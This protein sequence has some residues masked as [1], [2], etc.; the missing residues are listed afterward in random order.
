MD[1]SPQ[2]EKPDAEFANV[3]PDHERPAWLQAF[4]WLLWIAEVGAFLYLLAC[5]TLFGTTDRNGPLMP[6][7]VLA[8]FVLFVY[9]VVVTFNTRKTGRHRLLLGA[10]LILLAA[11]VAFTGCTI[12]MNM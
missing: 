11:F 6:L 2:P 3:A 1:S 9:G 7:V 8:S 10:S 4:F 5:A 12:A